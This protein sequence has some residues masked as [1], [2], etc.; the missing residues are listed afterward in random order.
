MSRTKKHWTLQRKDRLTKAQE[1]A[2]PG[3]CEKW[4][5]IALSTEPVDRKRAADAI[6]TAYQVY[7]RKRPRVVWITSPFQLSEE[8]HKSFGSKLR[9]SVRHSFDHVAWLGAVR[10]YRDAVATQVRDV[11]SSAVPAIISPLSLVIEADSTHWISSIGDN[12][13][14]TEHAQTLALTNFFN[15]ERHAEFVA[16]SP[17]LEQCAG[18]WLY[19][20]FALLMERPRVLSLDERGRLHSLNGPAI[21]YRDGAVV[22]AI[23]G[24]RV[25]RKWIDTPADAIDIADIMQEENA[26]IR[27]AL[28]EFTFPGRK[29]VS[30][31]ERGI[32]TIRL[33]A[34]HLKW[35]D[36]TGAR[37]TVLPVPRTLSEF[38]IRRRGAKERQM[39]LNINDCE[40]VR[41]W[42]L[43][44]PKEAI[45]VA[46]T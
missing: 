1:K 37:E 24:I 35:R 22:H 45:A 2:L 6:A 44:W 9:F 8:K 15:T 40:Q 30:A 20:K 7:R 21:E 17:V 29:W 43:G 38:G 4:R 12:H 19:E 11:I 39:R 23:H 41:R 27:A 18:F 36:K 46:E 25:D 3:I 16:F 10:F 32:E 34:L 28:I 26:G 31:E 13:L 33:R 14:G 42:T 5:Q